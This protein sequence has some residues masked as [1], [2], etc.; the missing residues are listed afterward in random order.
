MVAEF[1]T[2]YYYDSDKDPKWSDEIVTEIRRLKMKPDVTII[3]RDLNF[4]KYLL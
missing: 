3:V 4:A 1:L 2:R